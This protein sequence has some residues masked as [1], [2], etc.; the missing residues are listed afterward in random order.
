MRKQFSL[1]YEDIHNISQHKDIMTLPPISVQE[2]FM[3]TLG[4]IILCNNKEQVGE[5]I[6]LLNTYKGS[7]S[8]LILSLKYC[9]YCMEKELNKHFSHFNIIKFLAKWVEI[10]EGIKKKKDIRLYAEVIENLELGVCK[11]EEF[12]VYLN[13]ISTDLTTLLKSGTEETKKKYPDLANHP[14]LDPHDLIKFLSVILPKT[15]TNAIVPR[16]FFP[17]TLLKNNDENVDILYS[18][19]TL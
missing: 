12:I 14:H 17:P 9:N 15:L 16:N 1:A 3:Q 4:N 5:I 13:Y 7:F 6:N 2:S 18:N 11:Y 8:H 19:Q 10:L